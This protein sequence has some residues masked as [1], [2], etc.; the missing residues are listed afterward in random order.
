M[1]VELGLRERTIETNGVRLH[2]VEA[3]PEGAPLLIL[4]HGFPELWYG[5]RHQIEPLAAAGFHVLVPDQRGYNTSDK[6][7]R[8]RDYDVDFLARDIVGLID[9]AGVGKAYIA[10]HDWGGIVAWWLG[11]HHAER[12]E[13]MAILNVPH[14]KVLRDTML[15]SQKQRKAG[16]HMFAFQLP[17]LPERLLSK[18]NYAFA[19]KALKV[20][21]RPGTFT[22]EDFARYR[23]AW[24]QPRALRSMLNWYR[25]APRSPAKWGRDPVIRVPTLLIWGPKDRNLIREMA[26]PSIALCEDGRLEFIEEATHWVHHEEPERV[27]RLL[28]DFFAG[29]RSA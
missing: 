11:L 19:I 10:G 23:E 2:V 21:S 12:V 16:F 5:W 4:L 1:D 29:S 25:A 3:G 15:R 7:R 8:V 22:E 27:N 6:P 20:T 28:L 26:P 13:R 24:S 14:P 17:W 18:N 9:Q